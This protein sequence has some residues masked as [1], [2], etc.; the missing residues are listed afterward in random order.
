MLA[1]DAAEDKVAADRASERSFGQAAVWDCFDHDP[2]D[3]L[4]PILDGDLIGVGVRG[5][6]GREER[7][8]VEA[9]EG[10]AAGGGYADIVGGLPLCGGGFI[11]RLLILEVRQFVL[12]SF[13]PSIEPGEFLQGFRF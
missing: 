10:R 4:R 1:V 5:F 2:R 7:P 6:S 13:D 3:L 9:F 11:S 8:I 12:G